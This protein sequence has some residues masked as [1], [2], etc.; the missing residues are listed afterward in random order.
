MPVPS[1]QEVR[2]RGKE[3]P[4]FD[5]VERICSGVEVVQMGRK[6]LYHVV[7]S[8]GGRGG[9]E[10]ADYFFPTIGEVLN[11]QERVIQQNVGLALESSSGFITLPGEFQRMGDLSQRIAAVVARSVS[12]LTQSGSRHLRGEL[13]EFINEL[14]QV[15]NPDKVEARG[16]LVTVYER[17]KPASEQDVEIVS[18]EEVLEILR[19][20]EG[21]A[22]RMRDVLGKA[23]GVLTKWNLVYTKREDWEILILRKQTEILDE[24]VRL[25]RGNLSRGDRE[26]AARHI[27]GEK[28]GTLAVLNRISGPEYLGRVHS[29]EVQR[30]SQFGT[31]M[32]AGND[33]RAIR[34]LEDAA[35][36][37]ARVALD[38]EKRLK[39]QTPPVLQGGPAKPSKN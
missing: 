26:Q 25:R 18:P 29:R 31:L 30:L 38:R 6:R 16:R 19:S 8:R 17:T 32:R 5:V 27:S 23:Q 11:N 13:V 35:K 33:R 20:N 22:R 39:G 15:T 28:D 9:K 24:L 1:E 36:K 4:Q 37:L 10:Q 3:A 12:P 2:R 34:I 7:Y 14:E 21:L